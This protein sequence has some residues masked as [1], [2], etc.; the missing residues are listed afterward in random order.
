MVPDIKYDPTVR[1]VK[2]TDPATGAI[3]ALARWYIFDENP[4]EDQLEGDF[5]EDEDSKAYAV[6]LYSQY[7]VNRRAYVK[8]IDGPVVCKQYCSSSI[9][10]CCSQN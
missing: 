10:I 7:L 4:A 8:S 2:A 9:T 5:W 3:V 6:H 1:F